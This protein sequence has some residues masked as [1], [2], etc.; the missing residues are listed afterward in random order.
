MQQGQKAGALPKTRPRRP[1]STEPCQEAAG[2]AQPRRHGQKS[3]HGSFPRAAAAKQPRS[4]I[5]V[6]HKPSLAA[7]SELHYKGARAEERRRGRARSYSG[8]FGGKSLQ[9]AGRARSGRLRGTAWTSPPAAPGRGAQRH[10]GGRTPPPQPRAPLRGSR[11]Q[12]GGE[13][14]GPSRLPPRPPAPLTSWGR[15]PS[16]CRLGLGL[17]HR[18][19]SAGPGPAAPAPRRHWAAAP[20]AGPGPVQPGGGGQRPAGGPDKKGFCLRAEGE[21]RPFGSSGLGAWIP[22]AHSRPRNAAPGGRR[23]RLSLP[24]A[25]AARPRQALCGVPATRLDPKIC[26]GLNA[27]DWDLV[28]GCPAG[29]GIPGGV[30]I[31]QKDLQPRPS[32]LRQLVLLLH[33]IGLPYPSLPCNAV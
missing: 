16:R 18:G 6:A 27:K 20:G 9:K 29:S 11:P 21:A 8:S 2:T 22:R 14:G 19:P 17:L 31:L 5:F 12:P 24:S 25:E 28:T 33:H 13:A 23:C 4:S 3:H 30:Q 26:L 10:S 1:A 7:C 15:P 32:P